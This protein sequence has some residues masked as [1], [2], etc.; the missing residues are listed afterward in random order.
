MTNNKIKTPVY[1]DYH[2]TTP[3]DPRV[4]ELMLPWFTERFGNPHSTSHVFGHDAA[5][6]VE[7]ARGHVAALI[8]ADTREI[9]FT[10]GA[11]ESNNLAIKGAARF[12][13]RHRNRRNK[14]VT[15]ISEHKCVI[16]SVKDMGAQGFDT[17]MLPVGSG[18]VVDM[19]A[20]DAAVDEDT[21]LVSVM[22]ANNEIG[23]QQPIEEIGALTRAQGV[24]FHTDAAQAAGKVPIDVD[25][26]NID[27][28][29]ISGH[30]LYG[31]KGIGVLYVRRRPRARIEPLFSG[32]GQE[33]TI[34]SGTLAPPLVIGL[35][36]ACRLAKV[37]MEE[38]GAR[39]TALRTRFLKALGQRVGGV[40]INGDQERRLPGNINMR[41]EGIDALKLID[42]A[43]DLAFSTGSACTSA[44]VEPSHVLRGIGLSD[45]EAAS[46]VRIGLGRFTTADEVDFAADHLAEAIHACR[47]EASAA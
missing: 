35:G 25:A 6:A 19:D 8:G 29:S 13:R 46:S 23:L 18:G 27:L 26:A 37:E 20:L 5:E 40:T 24:L 16:E 34:R 45:E 12:E 30:K 42:H 2:A 31:P 3:V 1:L 9:V 32:G 43:P 14:L 33:R 41:I 28:L 4:L 36:E 47:H 38:E 21:I 44:V 39:I 7:Q 11:T 10:S 22:T 15:L 17:V